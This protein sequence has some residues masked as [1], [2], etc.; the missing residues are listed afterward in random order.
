[1]DGATKSNRRPKSQP[2]LLVGA[3]LTVVLLAGAAVAVLMSARNGPERQ[4]AAP[5][6]GGVTRPTPPDAAAPDPFRVGSVWT[7][8]SPR[9]VLTVTDRKGEQF[10]ATFVIGDKIE[11]VVTGTVQD[12][13]VRW[14]A[15]DVR[16][17]LG[18]VGGDNHG[19]LE[20][21]RIEFAWS[22][23]NGTSGTFVLRLSGVPGP[24][25]PVA[26]PS[27]GE[28]WISLFD[29]KTLRGWRTHPDQA[30]GWSVEEG[31]LT[32]R[33]VAAHHLF[34]EAGDYQDFHLRVEA[35]VN[36]FGN[37]GLYFRCTSD[38]PRSGR[39]PNGYEAQILHSHPRAGV[40][41]TGGL[42][43][44]ANVTKPLVEPDQWFTMEVI[45]QGQR[46]VIKVNGAVTTDFADRAG[47]FSRGHLAL[48][49]LSEGNPPMNTVVQFRKVE[50]R[51]FP[52]SGAP[53]SPGAELPSD[54]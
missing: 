21:D 11:R 18:G 53:P 9:K 35:R 30:R 44:I 41:L 6:G 3:A 54:E 33:S 52:P 25:P 8:D 29:G 22:G 20:S 49:A 17:V 19:T 48:Q 40:S 4:A 37:S 14:L 2:W 50:V 47:T 5:A 23:S 36:Q 12:G 24:A 31:L 46:T 43:A 1:V 42:H 51:K 39:Y 26:T 32:G 10:T 45:A 28:E 15:R 13:K 16:A 34:S 7:G 38:L 27:R